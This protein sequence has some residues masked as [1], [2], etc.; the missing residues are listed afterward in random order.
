MPARYAFFDDYSEGCHP[1]I[2]AALS[3]ANMSQQLAY[4]ADTFSEQATQLIRADCEAAAASVHLVPTGTVANTIC[5]AGALRPH[6]AVVAA[7][8]GHI[9]SREAGAIEATGHKIILVPSADG[10]L[11]PAGIQTALDANSHFPHMAKPRMVYLSQATEL[12]TVYRREELE[13]IASLCRANHLYLLLDGARLG[14]ALSANNADLN[15]AQIAQMTDLFWIGGTKAGALFGEAI[16]VTNPAL[17]DDV[18]FQVKQ[19][20][21][22]LAKGRALG[23]QFSTL[24]R[25]GLF[26]ELATH[27]NNMAGRIAAG[28]SQAGF[29]LA[30]PTDS[31]QVFPVLPDALLDSLRQ[32]FDFHTW[33]QREDEHT[34]VRLVTSWATDADQVE[35]LVAALTA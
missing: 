23:A 29:E 26:Y 8:T 2:L 3:S 12:G 18:S 32:Q 16:V 31:N 14:V 22:M 10:K 1:D 5:I 30:A 19:R 13:A 20:G 11:T 7:A 15:I 27:A 17:A 4:G 34:V 33:Q 28:V 21:A 25:D 24:F 35:R 9:V 6:E